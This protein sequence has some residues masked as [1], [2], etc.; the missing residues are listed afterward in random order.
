[1]VKL[2]D[3][4]IKKNSTGWRGVV[5]FTLWPLYL[6]GELPLITEQEA[7]Y[8]PNLVWTF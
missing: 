1:M 3:T 2:A 8:V 4:L 7:Q 6:S 5:N